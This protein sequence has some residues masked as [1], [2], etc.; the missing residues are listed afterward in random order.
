MGRRVNAVATLSLSTSCVDATPISLPRTSFPRNPK[1][2]MAS[3]GGVTLISTR[4]FVRNNAQQHRISHLSADR[5]PVE[6]KYCTYPSWTLHD[7]TRH[8]HDEV[9]EGERKNKLRRHWRMAERV[10]RPRYAL[11]QD[12]TTPWR[13]GDNKLF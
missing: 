2:P 8:V 6:N 10:P 5:R 12:A 4:H 13:K 1:E 9:W 7:V 11:Q 3:R